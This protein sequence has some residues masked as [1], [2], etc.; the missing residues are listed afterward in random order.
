VLPSHLNSPG[1]KEGWI[2]IM[3]PDGNHT[4]FAK[5]REGTASAKPDNMSGH[6]REGSL[7]ISQAVAHY[8]NANDPHSPVRWRLVDGN[9]VRPG[10]WLK[11]EE[12]SIVLTAIR[13]ADAAKDGATNTSAEPFKL[14]A[15]YLGLYLKIN[16][17]EHEEKS[18]DIKKTSQTFSEVLGELDAIQQMAPAWEQVLVAHRIEDVQAKLS[19]LNSP[20]S[21]V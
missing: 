6:V 13:D 2:E 18:G 5:W 20:K 11:E 19:E 14:R 12:Q 1:E 7:G 16:E 15:L 4:C 3:C 8:L 10:K 9:N 21:G 17:A